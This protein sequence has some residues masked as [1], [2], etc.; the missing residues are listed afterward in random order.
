MADTQPNMNEQNSSHGAHV[1][2][3]LSLSLALPPSSLP[4]SLVL[5]LSV[6]LKVPCAGEM[7]TEVQCAP[8]PRM[9][10]PHVGVNRP[11]SQTLWQPFIPRRGPARRGG[12]G[13]GGGTG[14]CVVRSCHRRPGLSA[15]R[16]PERCGTAACSP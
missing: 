7:Y 16:G 2:T 3:F 11:A 10:H 4:L 1:Y 9:N 8:P 5:S 6:D 13:G 15:P 14:L 12:G